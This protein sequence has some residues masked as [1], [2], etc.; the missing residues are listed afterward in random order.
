MAEP[1]AIVPKIFIRQDIN[2]FGEWEDVLKP[3]YAKQM[4]VLEAIFKEPSPSIKAIDLC[5]GRGFG[6]TTL[7]ILIAQAMLGLS[8]NQRGLF[9]EPDVP[10]MN[11]AFLEEWRKIVPENKY[12]INESKRVI[13]WLPNGSKLKYGPRVVTGNQGRSANKFKGR[14]LTFILDDEAADSFNV[15]LYTSVRACIRGKS[16]IRI[17]C[18][19]ST[20]LAGPYS[21]MIH[22]PGHIRITGT[23]YDN[24]YLD[25]EVIEGWKAEMSRDEFRREVLAEIISLEGR[26]FREAKVDAV[27]V[28]PDPNNRWPNGNVH[29]GFES[30]RSNQ[31]WY[32]FCDLGSATGAYLA[33]QRTHAD[34]RFPGDVWVAVAELCPQ[35][36]ASASRAFQRLKLEFGTPAAV[37]AGADI[38]SRTETDGSTVANIVQQVFG[39]VQI[40]PCD[41]KINSKITQYDCLSFL[42]CSTLDHRRFAIARNFKSLDRDSKRGLREML[43]QYAHREESKRKQNEFLPKGQDQPLCHIADALMMGTAMVMAPPSWKHKKELPK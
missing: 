4:E 18:T 22:R 39:N 23:S 17:H 12:R 34:G 37:V 2:E 35:N 3:P 33:V 20:P 5:C 28:E 38:G 40:Y 27:D 9:L 42:I 41:E 24:P 15:M 29:Y 21:E 10:T 6:K 8:S 26:V 7:L 25:P 30:F 1:I 14:N 16:P 43:Q 11:D 32:L 13:T 36:D 19:C 31:P